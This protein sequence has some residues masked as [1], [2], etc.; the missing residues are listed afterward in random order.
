[1]IGMPLK[2]ALCRTHGHSGRQSWE[3]GVLSPEFN[4]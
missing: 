2:T 3:I 4:N 1:V